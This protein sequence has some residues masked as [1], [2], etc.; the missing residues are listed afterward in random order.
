MS[1]KQYKVPYDEHGNLLHYPLK[2]F[3]YTKRGYVDLSDYRENAPFEASLVLC[4]MRRGRSAAYFTWVDTGVFEH[5]YPM[6]MSEMCNL[7]ILVS[8]MKYGVV[9]GTWEACKRGQNYGIKLLEE[10]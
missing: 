8:N 2:K 10:K 3:D 9:A 6:F 7:I 1:K 5:H 4:D